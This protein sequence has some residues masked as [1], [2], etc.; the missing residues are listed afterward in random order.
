MQILV[1]P[2]AAD[3]A[4]VVRNEKGDAVSS[5]MVQLFDDTRMKS[6]SSTDQNGAFHLKNLAPGEYKIFAWEDSSSRITQDA[7]FRKHFDANV[8]K[9][10]EKSH[11]NVEL[12]LILKDAIEAEAAKVQ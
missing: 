6:S 12:K 3:V 8:V 1:S 11:E 4:G 5:A 2:N 7:E 10:A 9:L